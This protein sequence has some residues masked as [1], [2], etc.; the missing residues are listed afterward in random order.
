[1][2]VSAVLLGIGA[3]LLLMGPAEPTRSSV[4]AQT[5]PILKSHFTRL[6][7]RID[8]VLSEGEW[9]G[10]PVEPF[11]LPMVL[12][13]NGQDTRTIAGDLYLL[14]DA[15]NF[16]V[17]VKLYGVTYHNVFQPPSA[18]FDVLALL[19]DNNNNGVV[20]PFEDRK[21]VFS[22]QPTIGSGQRG[23]YSDEHFTRVQGESGSDLHIDGTAR[24][25]HSD[26]G[27]VGD[28]I[29]EMAFPINSGYPDDLAMRPDGRVK[30]NLLFASGLGGP[31]FE[32]GAFYTLT[33]QDS[34]EWGFIQLEPGNSSPASVVP[35][36]AGKIAFITPELNGHDEVYVMN[37]DGTALLRLTNNDM[38][39]SW[40]ALSRDGN[41]V[42]F[43]QSR[44]GVA[45]SEEVYTINAN[46]TAL[47]RLTNNSVAENR[48]S[49]SPDGN[50][51][52][53]S[54]EGEI[55]RMRSDGLNLRRLTNNGVDDGDPDWGPDGRIVFRTRRYG[56]RDQ[57][58]IMNSD[59]SNTV[60]LTTSA[61]WDQNPTFSPDG[62]SVSFQRYEGPGS[63]YNLIV[64]A[65]Y[66]WNIYTIRANATQEVSFT[67]DGLFNWRPLFAPDNQTILYQ[68][69]TDL[70]T[71]YTRIFKAKPGELNGQQVLKLLSRVR[72]FDFK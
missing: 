4:T 37:S 14:N 28:Y 56:D 71:F 61:Y 12:A 19:F 2:R 59:G 58:A 11:I 27:G 60:R 65:Y 43:V 47:R 49:F 67:N 52:V 6:P 5:V 17:G 51:I 7:P 34:R 15:E 66:P 57:L 72:Y 22:F 9:N 55:W 26:P 1:M 64:S 48:P 70:S 30:F 54:Q 13:E 18:I 16:Y 32:V 39:K 8:G 40:V 63:P 31:S 23:Y 36:P 68:K 62:Q 46:G 44:P 41:R 53:F 29:I 35:L 50:D 20:E 69:T 42:V 45:G 10:A 24:M 21:F 25:V 3:I 38:S 33:D